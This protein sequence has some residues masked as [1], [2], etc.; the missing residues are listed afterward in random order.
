MCTC[1]YTRAHGRILWQS[2]ITESWVSYCLCQANPAPMYPHSVWNSWTLPLSTHSNPPCL[3]SSSPT[4][5]PPWTQ[6]NLPANTDFCI[7]PTVLIFTVTQSNSNLYCLVALNDC[8]MSQ[9]WLFIKA[10]N[11][12][13]ISKVKNVVCISFEFFPIPCIQHWY[14]WVEIKK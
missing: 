14:E 13:C 1:T 11:V 6:D 9:L 2:N 3:A 10:K 5:P 4:L 12:V 8:F 7:V